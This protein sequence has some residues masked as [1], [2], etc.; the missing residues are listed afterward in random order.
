M[1]ALMLSGLVGLIGTATAEGD[2]SGESRATFYEGATDET[3]SYMNSKRVNSGDIYYGHVDRVNDKSDY[4]QLDAA[5]QSIINAHVTSSATT[6]APSGGPDL[7]TPAGDVPS[8]MFQL[9]P[10]HQRG[11]VHSRSTATR[12]TPS[13]ATSA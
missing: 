5:F 1:L 4:F 3:Q 2:G 7:R 6:A 12:R 13:Y 11:H 10:V 8:A 9:F